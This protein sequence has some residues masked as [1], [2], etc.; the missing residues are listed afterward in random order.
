MPKK[1]LIVDDSLVSR[2]MIK[3][4]IISRYPDWEFT[5]AASSEKAVDACEKAQFDYI[6][7]DLNMPGENGL[8]VTPKVLKTQ[9]N[10]IVALV[11]ANL[12]QEVKDQASALGVAY[13]NKPINES[14]ILSLISG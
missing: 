11:T 8:E 7:I 13:I 2:M 5:Q 12:S 9:D 3:E 6:T 10:A 4:I 14:E 1:V